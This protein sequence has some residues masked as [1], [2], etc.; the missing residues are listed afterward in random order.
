MSV[1]K[2]KTWN[3]Q[4]LTFSYI[5]AGNAPLVVARGGFSGLFPDSSI[6]AYGV[7]V[8]N[9]LQNLHVW[10]DVQLTKDGK[11]ICVP[12]IKL[13]NASNI[14]VVYPKGRNTYVVNGVSTQGWFSVDFTLK[15]LANVNC[16]LI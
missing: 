6:S 5:L 13:E 16:K 3:A 4:R 8:Q 15:D 7:A 1:L 14:D 9:S 12:D 11:G 2:E 10:C